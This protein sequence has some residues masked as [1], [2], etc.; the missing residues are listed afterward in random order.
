[1]RDLYVCEA[2]RQRDILLEALDELDADEDWPKCNDLCVDFA[3]RVIKRARK[4]IG[5]A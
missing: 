3:R 2:A 4:K 5:G 1:M